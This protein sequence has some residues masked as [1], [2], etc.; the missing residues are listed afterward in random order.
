MVAGTSI[1]SALAVLRLT[2]RLNWVGSLYRKV[3]GSFSLQYAIDVGSR[4]TPLVDEVRSVGHQTAICYEI[5]IWI[6]GWK[7]MLC[8]QC[9]DRI[10]MNCDDRSG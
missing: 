5:S 1:P 3:L 7:A 9:D 10:A 6:D 4:L 8:C 2:T